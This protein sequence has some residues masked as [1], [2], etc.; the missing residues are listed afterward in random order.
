MASPQS[1]GN[2]YNKETRLFK[3]QS[4]FAEYPETGQ[5]NTYD[6]CANYMHYLQA[7]ISGVLEKSWLGRTR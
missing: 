4:N 2:N 3:C 7:P 6:K 1:A 5:S